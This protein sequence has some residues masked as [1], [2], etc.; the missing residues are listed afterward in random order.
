MSEQVTAVPDVKTAKAYPGDVLLL[1]C[2]GLL[3]HLTRTQ[4]ATLVHTHLIQ[5]EARSRTVSDAQKGAPGPLLS[6]FLSLDD[7]FLFSFS[8]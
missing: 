8:R 3:E 6:C 7:P 5:P 1:C 2:D 4:L